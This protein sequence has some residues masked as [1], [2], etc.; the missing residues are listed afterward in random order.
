MKIDSRYPKFSK[1]RNAGDEGPHLQL[2]SFLNDSGRHDRC[3]Q[4]R[5]CTVDVSRIVAEK[6]GSRPDVGE[7][8]ERMR[9]TEH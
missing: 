6:I 5:E 1:S 7:E 3:G 2:Q 8:G 4:R 9:G